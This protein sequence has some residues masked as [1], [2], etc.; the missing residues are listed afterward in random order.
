M[1]Q[2]M[3]LKQKNTLEKKTQLSGE[4]GMLDTYACWGKAVVVAFS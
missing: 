3:L 4:L 2:K 1:L